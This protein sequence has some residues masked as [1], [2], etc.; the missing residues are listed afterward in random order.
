[1]LNSIIDQQR[2]VRILKTLLRTG[3]IPHA[4]LFTGI[5]GVGKQSAAEAFA[6]ACN[7]R[8]LAERRSSGAPLP[9]NEVEPCGHCRSCRKIQSGTHPDILYL[10][11]TGVAIR[12]AQV[13]ELAD[14]LTLKPYEAQ[15]RVVI[16]KD[17]HSL[18]PHAGNALLKLL[19]E[20]PDRTIFILTAPQTADIMPT[21]L[22]RCQIL[23]F[24]PVSKARISEMLQNEGL[25]A[26]AA[27][28]L[29]AMAQGSPR[30]AGALQAKDYQRRRDWYVRASG[31]E[32]PERL[33]PI[34][35][36]PLQAFAEA[37][38]SNKD[39]ALEALESLM[40]WLRDLIVIR[41]TPE[42]IVNVDRAE[43][44]Q[45]AAA[46]TQVEWLLQRVEII[47]SAR[48]ALE[49]NANLRLTLEV[50]MLRLAQPAPPAG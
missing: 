25:D 28:M 14:T 48:R 36:G 20:P 50:M 15:T 13:R 23:H 17:A 7:C 12:I 29:A 46:Q 27:A 3:N 32:H 18:N 22:S 49:S 41:H 43:S 38:S 26:D 6:M 19:E 10:K 9:A 31:L 33:A 21:I 40:I 11:P 47:Q 4:L 1:V 16:I 30:R 39:R 2:P 34:P 5:E 42:H 45:A 37:L 24:Y 35:C 8:S 44:L